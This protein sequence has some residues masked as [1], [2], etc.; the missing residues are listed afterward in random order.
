MFSRYMI[1]RQFE[2]NISEIHYPN[3]DRI[4]ALVNESRINKGGFPRAR[5]TFT[6]NRLL[7]KTYSLFLTV[8]QTAFEN[9]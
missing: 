8:C 5:E 6:T 2:K 3:L 7:A 1:F 4:E 9:P